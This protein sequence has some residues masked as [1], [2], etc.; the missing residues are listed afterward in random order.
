[1]MRRFFK[2]DEAQSLVEFA[3][4]LPVFLILVFGI[5]DFGL[6]LRAYI[7]TAQATREGARYAAVGNPAGTFTSGGSGDCNGST[8]TS[9]VGRVCS[10]MNGLQLTNIQS[11]SVT[12][13]SGQL[14]GN[15]VRVSAEYRY[16]YIT[17][18]KAIV[19]F[20]SAGA[21]PGYLTV[22][23]STDMRLE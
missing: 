12:Y 20:L 5:I 6:G 3:F 4:V 8:T 9:T 10:A 21:L 7:T 23:S 15:P 17:P 1:M 22:S 18:V 2:R 19:N 11:V 16:Q 14:P 13:P